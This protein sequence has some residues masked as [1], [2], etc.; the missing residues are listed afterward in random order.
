MTVTA[1]DGSTQTYKINITRI[2]VLPAPATVPPD[3]S[4]S[5]FTEEDDKGRGQKFRLVFL[6]SYGRNAQSSSITD[7]NNFIRAATAVGDADIQPYADGFTVV[8]CTQDIDARDNTGTTGTGVPIYWLNGSKVADEYQDF[9]SLFWDAEGNS[10]DRNELGVNGTDTGRDS[11]FPWTGCEN[12]GT[13]ASATNGTSEALGAPDE[14]VRLGRPNSFST[15]HG[16]LSSDETAEYTEERPMYGL[17]QVFTVVPGNTGT[18]TTGGT[19]RSDTLDSSDTGHYWQVKLHQN[20]KYRIDVKGSESSQHG[21]TVTNPRIQVIAGSPD[22]ELL[23]RKANGVYQTLTTTVATGGGA[24][25]NSRLDI[26]VIGETKYYFLLAHR[27]AGDDGSYTVTVNRLDYPQ[28]RLAPDITVNIERFPAIGIQWEEPAKTH[29]SISAPIDGYKVQYRTLPNGTWETEITKN[30]SQRSHEITGMNTQGQKYEVRVRS[31]HGDPHPNNTYQWGY[32]T[33]Y[34]DDCN[35]E[36]TRACSID[37]NQIKNGRINYERSPNEDIDGY[38]VDLVSGRTYVIRAN[39]KSSGHGTLVDPHLELFIG[40]FHKV[41]SNDNG[42]SGLNS[43]L[44]YTPASTED[45]LIKVS[46]NV[47][48]ERGTYKVK[49]TEQ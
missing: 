46:S 35:D 13:E 14:Y 32:A 38:T 17:S 10:Q 5:P 37:V 8:G 30:Q 23:N 20:V 1:H 15:G 22:I 4:L 42:G 24:G 9:Y 39:G 27:G 40:E 25:H 36:G 49:V 48:G 41:A 21:G 6:S 34:N 43:K 11:N 3:W 47:A 45:Y 28:G 29:D 2:G 33:V 26:K 12:D 18:L 7:Y 31:Y 16:P 44:T 19:P